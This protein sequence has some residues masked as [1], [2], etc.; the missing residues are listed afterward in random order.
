MILHT[1]PTSGYGYMSSPLPQQTLLGDIDPEDWEIVILDEND[2]VEF[3]GTCHIDTAMCSVW[4]LL[5][6]GNIPGRFVAQVRH[7]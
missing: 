3:M 4:Y 7:G 6:N 2:P 1:H 5:P